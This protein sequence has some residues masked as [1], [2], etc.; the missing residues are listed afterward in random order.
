MVG[1]G[2]VGGG[3]KQQALGLDKLRYLPLSTSSCPAIY[4]PMPRYRPSYRPA[5][6]HPQAGGLEKHR[7]QL[8]AVTCTRLA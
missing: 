5:I 4:H 1:P 7:V 8:L 3:A 2:V 6:Y